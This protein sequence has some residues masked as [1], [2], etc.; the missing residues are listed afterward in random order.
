MALPPCVAVVPAVGARNRRNFILTESSAPQ[1][2]DQHIPGIAA[3]IADLSTPCPR[4][5]GRLISPAHRME[6][7]MS[8]SDTGGRGLTVIVEGSRSDLAASIAVD[9]A[10]IDKEIAGDILWQALLDLGHICWIRLGRKS[11]Q[12]MRKQPACGVSRQ[13]VTSE[14]R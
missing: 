13:K 10:G 7:G 2:P 1:P 9:A 14:A 12:L 3:A 6:P 4:K 5:R 11:H 8:S